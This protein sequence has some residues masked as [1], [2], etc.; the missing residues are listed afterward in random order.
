MTRI[1]TW[2]NGRLAA[3]REVASIDPIDEE[4][5]RSP[6]L[7]AMIAREARQRGMTRAQVIAEIK[8]DRDG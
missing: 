5:E 1:E 8:G 3:S 4:V 7:R 2:A 6:L